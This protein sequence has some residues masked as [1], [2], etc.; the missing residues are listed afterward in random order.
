MICLCLFLSVSRIFGIQKAVV[1]FS[2]NLWGG[3]WNK[4]Q[5]N[6]LW[7]QGFSSCLFVICEIV[8]LYYYLLGLSTIVYSDEPD[9]YI[10]SHFNVV[11]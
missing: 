7:I 5:S 9:S 3:P 4:K 10:V 8:L 2:W 1:E 6:T 11:K